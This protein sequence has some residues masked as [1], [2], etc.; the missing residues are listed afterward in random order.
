M[1]N[2]IVR[3]E[4]HPIEL[5]GELSLYTFI[6]QKRGVSILTAVANQYLTDKMEGRNPQ[7]PTIQ[8]QGYPQSGRRSLC[9]AFAN[10]VFGTPT[11]EYGIGKT[12]SFGWDNI[13]NY[14]Q[15]GTPSTMFFIA[16]AEEL[17]NYVQTVLCKLLREHIL[18]VPNRFNEKY[19]RIEFP[20]RPLI[21]FSICP[22][23]W[24]MPELRDVINL[25]IEMERYT[26]FE[27]IDILK[28]RCKY[29]GWS[30]K[31]NIL[32]YI[33]LKG[34]A[35]RVGRIIKI[36]E[37]TY[38]LARSCNRDILEMKDAVKAAELLKEKKAKS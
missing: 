29:L 1:N 38:Q 12:L 28:Q 14:I 19:E 7:L 4:V 17:T 35:Y 11:I 37:L 21:V 31:T 33:V 26:E 16:G 3:T 10:T 23:S 25:E 13:H 34:D 20:T 32:R 8:I 9:L 27:L 5:D 6:G 22:D 15:T 18:Y 24:L 2:K 36:L 30:A